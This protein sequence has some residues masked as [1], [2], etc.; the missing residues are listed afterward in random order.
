M[1]SSPQAV[2]LVDP[3]ENSYETIDQLVVFMQ[4][5]INEINAALTTIQNRLVAGGL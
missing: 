1:S 4:A 5:I 3:P 2:N